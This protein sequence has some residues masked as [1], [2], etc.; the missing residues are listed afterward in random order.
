MAKG[1]SGSSSSSARASGVSTARRRTL[2]ALSL[3]RPAAGPFAREVRADLARLRRSVGQ[4]CPHFGKKGVLQ[5]AMKRTGAEAAHPLGP[6]RFNKYAGWV[7]WRNAV[8]LWINATG[9]SFANTFKKGGRQVTWY[10]GGPRPSDKSP[11]VKRLL[12]DDG[13]STSVELF[14]RKHATTPYVY[15][16]SCKRVSHNSATKGF[17]FTWELEDYE[18]LKGKPAFKDL[19]SKKKG[20]PVER[21]AERWS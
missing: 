17:E 2:A 15:C 16:G 13:D 14:I 12:A 1:S 6:P 4:P 5:F 9:G 21:A 20:T 19:L 8:F 18:A 10:V 7:E 11:I 3:G